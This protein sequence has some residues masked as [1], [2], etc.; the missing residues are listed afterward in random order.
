MIAQVGSEYILI[1]FSALSRAIKDDIAEV[2][3]R[4]AALRI[5]QKGKEARLSFVVCQVA[6]NTE[7]SFRPG[8]P[9]YH[10]LDIPSKFLYQTG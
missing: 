10:D 3:R 7:I 5:G 1:V 2:T 9:R 6:A 8:E 4:V